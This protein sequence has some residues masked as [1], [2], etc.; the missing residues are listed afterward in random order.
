MIFKDNLFK[1][2]SF[3]I[4]GASSGM[5]AHVALTLNELGA[6]VIAIARSEKKLQEQKNQAKSP[7]NF[8]CISKDLSDFE[9]LDTWT[10]ELCKEFGGFDGAVLGAGISKMASIRTPNYIQQAQKIFNINY[11]GNLQVLKGMVDR[12]ARSRIGSSFVWIASTAGHKASKG[13]CLYSGSKA[14]VIASVRSIALEIA[15]NFRINSVSPGVVYTPLVETIQKKSLSYYINFAKETYPLGLGKVENISPTIC[16]LLS[17]DS[18]WITGR[19]IIL[20]GGG[21]L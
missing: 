9:K 6:K 13:I 15:P 5:G 14:A 17:E 20:D 16:F 2:K 10:L 18:S 8:I 4:T 11:F 1:D 12:R 7:E 19:D 3:L 21:E